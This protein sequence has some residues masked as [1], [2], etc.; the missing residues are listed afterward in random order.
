MVLEQQT[1]HFDLAYTNYRLSTRLYLTK[2]ELN[3]HLRVC[4]F[5]RNRILM[6]EFVYHIAGW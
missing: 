3:R 4:I 1:G 2:V 5:C 6:V